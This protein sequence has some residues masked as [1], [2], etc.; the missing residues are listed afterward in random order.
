MPTVVGNWL[1]DAP[2]SDGVVWLTVG[3]LALTGVAV[4]ALVLHREHE[5]ERELANDTEPEVPGP[6][7]EPS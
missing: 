6:P 7:E 3:C 1:L 2:A 4:V 5:H